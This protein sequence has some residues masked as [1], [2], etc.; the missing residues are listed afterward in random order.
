[1][2]Q[3][4]T[5]TFV[6]FF[7]VLSSTYGSLNTNLTTPLGDKG[8][9]KTSSPVTNESVE[10][11]LRKERTALRASAEF[12]TN[13]A[14]THLRLGKLLSQK[15]DP[16]GAI[17]EYQAAIL[18]NP[19]LGEAYRELGA[20]YIDKH[21]WENAE[22]ALRAGTG[23]NP[24]DSNAL[25]WL[26]R[27]LIAQEQFQEAQKAFTRAIQFDSSNPEFHSDLG[28][29]FMPQ[30]QSQNA[31]KTLKYA[32]TLQPDLAETHHRLERVRAAGENSQELIQAARDIL[33]TLF[34]RK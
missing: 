24:Q 22:G 34:R 30:G 11:G 14:P 13:D 32:I 8:Q 29:T 18:L 15:G 9:T 4:S 23:I 5:F 21:E 33:Q 2:K 10:A 26:G 3:L 27:S 7:V 16:N 1:M 31:E 28:L 25:Y 17:E 6:I 19:I 20:V 12:R